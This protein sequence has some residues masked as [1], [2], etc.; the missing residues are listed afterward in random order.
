MQAVSGP[1]IVASHTVLAVVAELAPF[2][3]GLIPTLV[4]CVFSLRLFSRRRIHPAE[5]DGEAEH[6]VARG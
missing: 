6:N 5:S 3:L 4:Q 2:V 1:V